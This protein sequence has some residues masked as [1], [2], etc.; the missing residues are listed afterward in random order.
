MNKAMKRLKQG[1]TLIELMIVVAIVGVLAVL[2]IYGVRKYIANSKSTEAR[3]SLGQISK[4]V[5]TAFAKDTSAGTA[6]TL[7]SQSAFIYSLCPSGG[8]VP[9]TVP[10]A[11]KYQSAPTDWGKGTTSSSTQFGWQCVG[12]NLEQPQYYSYTYAPGSTLTGDGAT[13]AAIAHGDLNGDGVNSTFQIFGL[14]QSSVLA[15]SPT[16]SE[17]NPLE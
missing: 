8:P 10:K 4:D 16:I 17:D 15:T 6:M 5:A 2:A 9:S 11:T 7:G 3:N 14:V 1:F 13:Y 12:F